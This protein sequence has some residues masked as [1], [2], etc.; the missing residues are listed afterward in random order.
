MFQQ[1]AHAESKPKTSW[2]R[3]LLAQLFLLHVGTYVVVITGL[4]M[5]NLIAGIGHPWFLF[6]AFAG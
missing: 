5:I 1:A 6:P 2:W 3:V 4:F